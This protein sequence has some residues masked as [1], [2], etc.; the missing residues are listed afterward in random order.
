MSSPGRGE[1]ERVSRKK[2]STLCWDVPGT[3]LGTLR[4]ALLLPCPMAHK[5][6]AA[7]A[8]V[9]NVRGLSRREGG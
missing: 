3:G 4:Q 1:W 9:D 6:E 8:S 2:G 5:G 7:E